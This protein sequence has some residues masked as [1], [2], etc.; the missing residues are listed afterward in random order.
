MAVEDDD[1][2]RLDSDS[3]EDAP[4]FPDEHPDDADDADGEGGAPR[5]L[6][7]WVVLGV[8]ALG[9]F[10]GLTTLFAGLLR[11]AA[12]PADPV[13]MT[14]AGVDAVT[15]V[16]QAVP[17]ALDA[18]AA[19]TAKPS[20]PK[21][22]G[23]D[24]APAVTPPPA[25]VGAVAAGTRPA[26]PRVAILI[27]EAGLNSATTRRAIETLPAAVAIGFSPHASGLAGQAAAARAAGHEVWIGV[28]MEP[29][30][31]P[32]IDPGPNTLLRSMP[33][34]ENLRRLD[35]ALARVARPDGVY[36]MMGSAFTSDPSALRPVLT[37]MA[38]RRL[39]F[40]DARSIGST[41]G[42]ALARELGLAFAL[43]DRFIDDKTDLAHVE[44]ALGDLAGIARSRGH[45]IGLTRPL[46]ETL[47]PLNEWLAGLPEKG[48][49]LVPLSA[50][51]N[52]AP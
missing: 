36:S 5:P 26:G 46:P 21:A 22:P 50:M 35:W 2:P 4:A 34:A 40:V 12:G 25:P 52:P 10:I 48:I 47:D 39:R 16:P 28:P 44:R 11:P 31:Y 41:R 23:S 6:W 20:P 7:Q 37:R 8:A 43:N 30:R 14:V 3:R 15:P 24:A 13:A 38:E 49:T 18:G 33:A 17:A 27:T 32:A 9:L 1:T 19:A 29:K 45:A 51:A 42:P